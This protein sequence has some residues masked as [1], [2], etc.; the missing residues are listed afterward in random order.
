M[1][2]LYPITKTFSLKHYGIKDATMRYQLSPKELQEEALEKGQGQLTNSGTLAVN[3][4]EFT[5]RSPMDRFI[6]ED[7]ITK[8][9]IWCLETIN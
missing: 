5:G 2:P 7:E 8:D 6:V 9:K 4:G 3:T 1:E